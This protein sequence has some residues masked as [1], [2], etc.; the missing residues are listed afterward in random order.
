MTIKYLDVKVNTG[1]IK[2]E[3]IDLFNMCFTVAGLHSRE[4]DP[5]T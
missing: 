5:R 1:I 3:L 2:L 4:D